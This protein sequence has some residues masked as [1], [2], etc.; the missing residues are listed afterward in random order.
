MATI[1]ARPPQLR[2]SP[3]PPPLGTT[4]SL[5]SS[6]CTFPIPNKHLPVCPPGSPP[7]VTPETPPAS[8]PKQHARIQ[9]SSV[10]N[11]PNNFQLICETPP[12]YSID[13][14]GLADA[15]EHIS[16]QPLPEPE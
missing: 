6:T 8:P 4:L 12:L 14:H 1:V 2:S 7:A 5:D 10:L 15:F 13:A 11:P 9:T 16:S 3:T